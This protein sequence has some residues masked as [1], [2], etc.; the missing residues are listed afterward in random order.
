MPGTR[1]KKTYR[2]YCVTV[3][4]SNHIQEEA[5]LCEEELTLET[6]GPGLKA[7]HHHSPP[8]GE[9]RFN[10]GLSFLTCKLGLICFKGLLW[11]FT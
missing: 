5:Q 11:R 1:K 4:Y 2:S 6:E 3:I 10:L 9:H 7:P 8:A